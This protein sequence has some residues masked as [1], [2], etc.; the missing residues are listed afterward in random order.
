MRDEGADAYRRGMSPQD[1]PYI[2]TVLAHIANEDDYERICKWAE[3]WAYAH[4]KQYVIQTNK[5]LRP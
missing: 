4:K 3:G 1:N 2:T 5:D